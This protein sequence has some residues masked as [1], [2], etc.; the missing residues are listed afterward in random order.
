[1]LVSG[2]LYLGSLIS[3][4]PIDLLRD[5]FIAMTLSS[6]KPCSVPQSIA[7]TLGDIDALPSDWNHAGT[8]PVNVLEAMVRHGYSGDRLTYTIETG[9]GKST[10]L[11]SN[12]SRKHTVFCTNSGEIL[13][14]IQNST[15]ADVAAIE[16]VEGPSQRTLPRHPFTQQ[17]QLILIDGP[18]GYPFP[19]LEYYFLYPHLA[20]GGLLVIDDIHIPSIGN[21]FETVRADAMFEFLEIVGNTAF[22]RRTDAPMFDPEGD[23]WWRQ[24]YNEQLYRRIKADEA[25]QNRRRR[26]R[27]GLRQRVPQGVRQMVP[28]ELKR[29]F[30][31]WG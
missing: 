2:A 21:M 31:S 12:L 16:F 11:L 28:S 5:E 6:V 30:R 13:S 8:L 24:G 1:L 26:F 27:D 20:I 29:L 25:R 18:H 17:A 23:G 4:E 3:S 14:K 15:I 19:D 22:L 7:I 9:S 10:L